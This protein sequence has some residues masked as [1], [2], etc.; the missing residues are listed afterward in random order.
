MEICIV[1]AGYVGLTT[2]VCFAEMGNEVKIIDID[3]EK[4]EKIKSGIAPIYEEGLQKLM[5]KNLDR[6]EATT[7][8]SIE[9]NII[10]ICVGTP[11]LPDGKINLKYVLDAAENVAKNMKEESIIVIKSTIFPGTTQKIVKPLIEKYG[12]KFSIAMNPE[13]LREGKAIYD[14]MNPDR[15]VIGIEDGKAENVLR[16]LYEPIKAPIIITTP[17]EAEMIKYASNALLATKISFANEIGN[18]CKILGIDVYKVMKGVGMDHRI[19]PYFLDAGIGFG[20]SC[21]PKDLKA[22]YVGSKELGYEMDLI[23]AVLELNDKQPL[24]VIKILEKYMDVN[25]KN[26]AVLG[27]AF[28]ANTD[29]VRESRSIPIIEKLMEKGAIIKAYD[30]MAMENM[31]KFFPRIIYCKSVAEALENADACLILT[32]WKEFEKLDFSKMRNKLVIEGRKVLKSREGIIYEGV[33]W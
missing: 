32:D 22:L 21:F 8:Y 33:C 15:I 18:L 29:D 14:F 30:P 19:S 27:L 23:K 28:K 26:I 1:G 25:G 11:S 6:I 31:K 4:I 2:A 20:G 13:F 5:E 3:K 17:T 16:K 9:E 24:Q 10:F 12:K 7:S